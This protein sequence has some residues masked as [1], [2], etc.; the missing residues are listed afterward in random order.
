[1]AHKNIEI[2]IQVQIQEIQALL[3]W[4]EKNA[5]YQ[6]TINQKDEYF[7]PSHRNFLAVRPANEWLRLREVEGCR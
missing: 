2:E 4:L 7:T 1:M 6:K 5:V 3:A